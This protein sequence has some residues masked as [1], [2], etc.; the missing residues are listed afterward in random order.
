MK[1][2]SVIIILLLGLVSCQDVERMEKPEDLIPKDKMA[3]VLLEMSL[4]Q[5]AKRPEAEILAVLN[6]QEISKSA[7]SGKYAGYYTAS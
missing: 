6:Q 1:Y 7:Y 5:G 4:L 2:S 3:D